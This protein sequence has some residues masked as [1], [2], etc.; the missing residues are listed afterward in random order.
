[1][2]IV[3]NTP[4]MALASLAVSASAFSHSPYASQVTF[5]RPLLRDNFKTAVAGNTALKM[6]SEGKG[7]G[8]NPIQSLIE[9]FQKKAVILREP[10]TEEPVLPDVIVDPDFN[11]ALAFA[12][13]GTLIVLASP[14]RIFGAVFGGLI[15]LFASFI[16]VQTARVRFV[17]EKDAFE[18]KVIQ[19]VGSDPESGSTLSDSGE[20]FVVGGANRWAYDKFVNWEFFPNVDFPILV[21]FKETQTPKEQWSV[22]PGQLDKVGGG[23]VHFFPCIANS[24]QLE[25]QFT[26][27]GCAKK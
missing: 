27:R 10:E 12:A 20:N 5:S 4:L 26:V 1:M 19:G 24:K 25:E 23:Q 14:S 21:Y 3:M 18:L 22:G 13:F 8:G 6:S 9:S 7:E 11:L 2:K 15:I 16:A 17:F